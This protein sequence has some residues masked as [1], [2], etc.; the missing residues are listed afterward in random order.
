MQALILAAGY[1]ERMKPLSEIIP[2]PLLPLGGQCLIENTL[3]GLAEVGV[4]EVIIN[5]SCFAR[6]IMT[7]LEDGRRYGLKISYSYEDGAPAGTGGGIVQALSLLN[8]QPFIVIS[9]DIWT[10]YPMKSLLKHTD[11]DAHLVMVDNPPYHLEGDFYLQQGDLLSNEQGVRLTYANIG[12]LH[13][14]IF[15]DCK[16]GS[17]PL[18]PTLQQAVAEGRVTGEYFQGVWFN[19]G[20]PHE[21]ALL[22]NYLSKDD[23]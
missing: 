5:V 2:K 18:L 7:Q 3:T 19:V 11:C 14:R 1:G 23:K 20:T 15:A 8:N 16:P 17:Y 12:V 4:T 22:R 9:G 13:P 10:G 21:L 6:Q